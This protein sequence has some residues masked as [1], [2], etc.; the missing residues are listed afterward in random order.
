VG[1]RT[2]RAYELVRT[3]VGGNDCFET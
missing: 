2:L 3:S 1:G